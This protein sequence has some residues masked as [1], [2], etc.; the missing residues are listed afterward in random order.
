MPREV[1]LILF[2]YVE[3]YKAI[4]SLCSQNNL[5]KPMGGVVFDL[6]IES[7]NRVLM[8]IVDES[9]GVKK[10]EEYNRDFL[11]AALMLYCRGL[12]IPLPKGA[13][14]TVAISENNEVMLRVRVDRKY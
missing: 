12:A 8:S 10:V 14:K 13:E 2:D 1:R 11:A 4:Y 3:V 9:S 5:K 7:D 6:K